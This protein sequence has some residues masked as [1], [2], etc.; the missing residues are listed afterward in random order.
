MA[1]TLFRRCEDYS[2]CVKTEHG[3]DESFKKDAS[4]K[5]MKGMFLKA[6]LPGKSS[7]TRPAKRLLQ[8]LES[9][10]DDVDVGASSS[11]AAPAPVNEK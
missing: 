6:R 3:S 10:E 1:R 2:K 4:V 7:K 11:T 9:D 8:E 5:E